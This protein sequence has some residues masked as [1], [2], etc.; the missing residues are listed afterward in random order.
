MDVLKL[1]LK[2]L[3]LIGDK[4]EL[5]GRFWDAV[6]ALNDNFNALGF[7]II[8]IFVL[9][10]LGSYLVYRAREPDALDART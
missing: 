6:G 1:I 8:G 7:A 3:G 10:W 5:K 4:L 2:A 9:A